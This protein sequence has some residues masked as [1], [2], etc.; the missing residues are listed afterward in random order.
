[1]EKQFIFKFKRPLVLPVSPNENKGVIV[2]NPRDFGFGYSVV[3]NPRDRVLIVTLAVFELET[4]TMVQQINTYVITEAGFPTGIVTNQKDIDDARIF[5]Q[6]TLD[7]LT[8]AQ[9]ELQALRT[10]EIDLAV[11]G[12]TTEELAAISQSIKDQEY[13]VANINI[14]L[15]G[16]TVPPPQ[17]LYINKYSDVIDYFDK[18]GSI[19]SEG[20]EWAKK[21][22]FLGMTLGDFIE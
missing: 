19:T 2:Y 7:E 20:I 6:Q 16:I 3:P 9:I 14:T 1:M 17:Y 4:S 13:L 21:I 15:G 12:A 10:H 22:S 18:D 11:S 8:S 5:L